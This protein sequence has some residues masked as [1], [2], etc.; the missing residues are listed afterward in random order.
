MAQFSAESVLALHD[1]A[2]EN[3][4]AA[5]SRTDH[6]RNRRL[7]AV[8]SKDGIVAPERSRIGVVQIA[9][10]PAEFVPQART[11]IESRPLRMDKVCGTPDA[12]LARCTGRAGCVEPYS[13]D[14]LNRNA[15]FFSGYLETVCDLLKALLGSL[16]GKGGMFTEVLNEKL[17]LLIQQGIVDGSSAQIHSGH[18]LH[19]PLL[20]L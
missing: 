7:A 2:I 1:I 6:D 20:G 5:I 12:E 8:G 19:N 9:H 17:L 14:V 11:D 16:L 10:R 18:C 3:D 4:A 13:D 15:R